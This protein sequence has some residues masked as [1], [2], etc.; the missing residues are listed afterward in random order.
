MSSEI[1]RV[2]S[3]PTTTA[4]DWYRSVGTPELAPVSSRMPLAVITADPNITARNA[5]MKP[6]LR[7]LIVAQ[8]R[9]SARLD[10]MRLNIRSP[11]AQPGH[12]VGDLFRRGPGEF[13]GQLAVG[14]EHHG[15]RMRRGA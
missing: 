1:E 4:A 2:W 8:A 15:V 7:P 3:A 12:P 5:A 13:A 9:D 6:P 10:R 11:I 14:E